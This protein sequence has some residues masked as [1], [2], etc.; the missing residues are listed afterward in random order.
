MGVTGVGKKL[1]LNVQRPTSNNVF[2]QF[3]KMLGKSNLPFEICL[4]LEGSAVRLYKNRSSVAP[5]IF[6]VRC[7]TFDVR[8]LTWKLLHYVGASGEG[9]HRGIYGT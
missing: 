5:S 9:V 4:T 8:R 1:T 6:D 7:W 3:S 2:Y